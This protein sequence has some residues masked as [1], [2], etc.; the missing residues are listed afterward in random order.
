MPFIFKKLELSGLVLVQPKIFADARGFFAET[1]KES[2]FLEQGIELSFKQD[3][4][5]LSNKNVLRGLHYQIG[6][7]AQ[8]QMVQVVK[9]RV[10]DVVVDIRANSP[11]FKKWVGT[12]LND[13]NHYGLYM[14]PGFAHG[15]VVLSAEACLY[16][17]CTAEYNP[18]IERGIKWDDPELDIKWPISRPI[19]SEKDEASPLLKD[20]EV[21]NA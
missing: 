13:E 7:G 19:V 18:A 3:D 16:Y 14:P 1:F 15:F 11:T 17:K 10:W 20:A 2:E 4:L 12:E 8:G 5:T 6:P 21:F 9:G